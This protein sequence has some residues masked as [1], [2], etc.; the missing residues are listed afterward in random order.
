MKMNEK[1][2]LK[3]AITAVLKQRHLSNEKMA[4]MI[5]MLVDSYEAMKEI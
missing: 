3:D 1:Q 2:W 4:E 5:M